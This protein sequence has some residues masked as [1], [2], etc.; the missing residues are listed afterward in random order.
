MR[1]AP[2]GR[3][4]MED[5]TS[6]DPDKLPPVFGFL[7]R[8]IIRNFIMSVVVVSFLYGHGFFEFVMFGGNFVPIFARNRDFAFF[9]CDDETAK[10]SSVRTVETVFQSLMMKWLSQGQT[11]GRTSIP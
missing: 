8:G 1:H 7:L 11:C 6:G 4:L 3:K 10:V 9:T 2:P 5:C